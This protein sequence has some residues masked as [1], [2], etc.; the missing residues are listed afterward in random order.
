MI[1]DG[2][3]D[4][5]GLTATLDGQPLVLDAQGRAFVTPSAPGKL[6]VNA[7]ATDADGLVG[8]ATVTLRV[9]DASDTASPVVILDAATGD[10]LLEDGVVNGTVRDINLDLWTLEIKRLGDEAFK[11]VVTNDQSI[12]QGRLALLDVATIPNGFYVLRLTA[13]D[14]TGRLSRTEAVV[15][16]RTAQ[17]RAYTR[18]E[19]DVIVTLGG[20]AVAMARDYDST[21]RDIEGRLGN[22]WRL[23]NREVDLRTNT[24]LT[25]YEDQGLYNPYRLG[26]R[27]YLDAPS[28][29]EL[30]FRFSPVRHDEPGV[31]YYTPAWSVLP[32]NPVGWTLETPGLKLMRAGD[33]FFELTTGR[34]YNPLSPFFQGVDFALTDPNGARYGIDAKLGIVSRTAPGGAT[35][36]V[37]DSGLVATNGDAV[38]FVYDTAGRIER[39][40]GPGDS[41]LIYTYDDQGD[42][43]AARE[44]ATGAATRYGYDAM[45]RLVTFTETAGA[46]SAITYSP[47]VQPVVLPIVDNLGTAANFAGAPVSGVLGLGGTERH[48]FAV[49]ASEILATPQ[50]ELLVRVAVRATSGTLQPTVPQIAGLTPLST[51]V[52]SSRADAL[53]TITRE[54]LYHITVVQTR[55]V[56]ARTSLTSSSRATSMPTAPWTASIPSLGQRPWAAVK[57]R[58]VICS[59]PTWTAVASS[60]APTPRS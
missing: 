8:H 33:R 47:T 14:M 46:G 31:V 15:E 58:S 6:V 49:R 32:G 9:R 23:L 10:S 2:F 53:F 4:I 18:V 41:V 45:H 38:Q 20:A 16:V 52:G 59:R 28:G 30:G 26:T 25:G 40:I 29:E 11:P 50:R 42:L 24:P 43:V 60:T 5:T 17:K 21:R 7:V 55:A 54:S 3:A 57:A 22:G 34:P 48:A 35:V 36:Y 1:A 19:N 12:E 51:F 13:R 37:G 56:R 27:L 39:I 44:L